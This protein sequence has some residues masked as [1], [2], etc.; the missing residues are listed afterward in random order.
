MYI[1]PTHLYT[2]AT[3][4]W[5][6]QKVVSQQYYSY[7]LQIIYVISDK[8]KLLP[9]YPPHLQNVTALPCK[10]HNFF[11]WPKVCSIPPNV[12]GS[13]MSRL[14]VGICGSEKNRGCDAWQME[15]QASNVTANV[16]KSVLGP[17]FVKGG[18]TPDFG[19]A[20]LN[21]R[22][23]KFCILMLRRAFSNC[24]SML[25]SLFVSW[26]NRES[27]SGWPIN[28]LSDV[29]STE[30]IPRPSTDQC[31]TDYLCRQ[32]CRSHTVSRVVDYFIGVQRNVIIARNTAIPPWLHG[33][34]TKHACVRQTDRQTDGRTDGRTDRIAI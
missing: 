16:E 32:P 9:R 17:R 14:W 12:G 24:C 29:W 28:S 7:I 22:N 19:H 2:V 8:N 3:L 4:P 18:Y 20:F 10:M 15:Y 11:I 21:R 34:V 31:H 1:C 6:I 25:F 23:R 33:F 5:E 26:L 27:F 30:R 13:E